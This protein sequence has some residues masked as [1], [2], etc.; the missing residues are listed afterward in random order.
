MSR[1]LLI[2]ITRLETVPFGEHRVIEWIT[3]WAKSR[4]RIQLGRDRCGNILL[5]LP[6]KQPA[7]RLVMV[8][9]MDHPGFTALR[10]TGP[11][12]LQAR[13][14]GGVQARYFNGQS[15]RFLHAIEKWSGKFWM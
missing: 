15:V 8:A 13:F 14:N 5:T 9:H 4:P 7:P 3:D 12:T 6:G 10:M 1:E 2:L 11:Q